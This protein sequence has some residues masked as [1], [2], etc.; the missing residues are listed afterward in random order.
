MCN[1]SG[2]WQ[3]PEDDDHWDPEERKHSSSGHRIEAEYWAESNL[4]QHTEKKNYQVLR[5]EVVAAN[6][7]SC[8][9]RSLQIGV[10]LLQL[11]CEKLSKDTTMSSNQLSQ[12]NL[13]KSSWFVISVTNLVAQEKLRSGTLANTALRKGRGYTVVA[14]METSKI[15]L[16]GNTSFQEKNGDI[17][18]QQRKRLDHAVRD[19]T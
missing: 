14:V 1:A 3:M 18:F 5:Y 8:P 16:V 7:F 19:S 9:I 17:F 12:S 10:L 6:H 2:V 13:P 15:G 11:N 4:R